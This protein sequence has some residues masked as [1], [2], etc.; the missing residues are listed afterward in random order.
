M[1]FCSPVFN[2]FYPLLDV[3]WYPTDS[4]VLHNRYKIGKPETLSFNLRP[5]QVAIWSVNNGCE[6][7]STSRDDQAVIFIAFWQENHAFEYFSRSVKLPTCS[8][9]LAVNVSWVLHF[10]VPLTEN[11]KTNDKVLGSKR[12]KVPSKN[13]SYRSSGSSHKS[14]FHTKQNRI[15]V[16]WTNQKHCC[17]KE[18]SP[19]RLTSLVGLL[20]HVEHTHAVWT[21]TNKHN[22]HAFTPKLNH[23]NRSFMR[24]FNRTG[25][26]HV[27]SR[28]PFKED[29]R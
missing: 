20:I 14:F 11:W 22:V 23:L 25:G 19:C 24:E 6:T 12:F 8:S 1:A 18:S 15:T 5:P 27:L 21:S 26:K 16:F 7:T 10:V 9:Q 13:W 4:T 3:S 28:W 29:N 2:H 17:T